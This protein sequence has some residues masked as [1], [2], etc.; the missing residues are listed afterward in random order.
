MSRRAL[1]A[2]AAAAELRL[3]AQQSLL[4]SRTTALRHRL[5]ANAVIWTVGGGLLA[6]L[7]A[8]LASRTTAGAT[9]QGARALAMVTR[10]PLGPLFHAAARAFTRPPGTP[11]P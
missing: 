5:R 10:L 9:R 6:G 2:A 8:G 11:L 7:A 3:H 4:T 1:R